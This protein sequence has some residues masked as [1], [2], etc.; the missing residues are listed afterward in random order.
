MTYF[1]RKNFLF[2][3]VLC[4]L[5]AIT[6][7][8]QPIADFTADKS[9][10]CAPVLIKF[11]NTSTQGPI[12]YSWDFGNG[13]TSTEQD[14]SILFSLPGLYTV[15]LTSTNVLG[16]TSKTI[17]IPV[18]A[19]P[20]AD[21]QANKTDLCGYSP[22]HFTDLSVPQ[23]TGII[24]WFWSFGDG[25]FSTQQN[26]VHNYSKEGKFNVYLQ[27]EDAN[28]CTNT[29][30][31]NNYIN[32]NQP[33]ADFAA[34]TFVCELPAAVQFTNKSTGSNLNYSWNFGDGSNS[35]LKSPKHT[36]AKFDT[37]QVSMIVNSTGST[38]SDTLKKTIRITDYKTNFNYTVSCNGQKDFTINFNNTGNPVG[39]INTW[40]FGDGDT[41][42]RV[43]PTHKFATK[44]TYN[45]RLI[46]RFNNTCI[47]T[48]T[49]VYTSPTA[50][51]TF[52]PLS[53]KAPFSVN[54]VNQS[55]GSNATS[56]WNF[57]N[58]QSSAQ[59]NPTQTYIVPPA[60]ATA[61]LTQSNV[62]GCAHSDTVKLNFP[63]PIAGFKV[64]TPFS[65]CAPLTVTLKDNSTTYGSPI[66]KWNWNFG[67]STSGVAN[68]STLKSPTHT[69]NNTGFYTVTLTVE[70][71]NGCTSSVTVNK[72]VKTGE[73]PSLVDFVTDA[74]TFCFHTTH[75]YTDK[76]KYSNPS[77]KP[78]YWC[79]SMYQNGSD[80][81]GVNGKL[82]ATCPDSGYYYA[83]ED[84][85]AIQNPQHKYEK[86]D[87]HQIT[88]VN[89]TLWADNAQAKTGTYYVNMIVGNNGCYAEV[90]KK[91]FIKSNMSMPNY[92]F[93]NGEVSLGAC[94]PPFS[95]GLFN[96]STNWDKFNYFNVVKRGTSDTII[97]LKANDTS[98]INITHSG[99]YDINISTTNTAQNC[100]DVLSRVI[101]VDSMIPKKIVQSTAC[102]NEPITLINLTKSTLGNIYD[103]DWDFGDNSSLG[104]PYAD[105]TSKA[106][107]D[108][109]SFIIHAYA[110]ARV[111]YNYLSA[112]I[113]S[114]Q[115][116]QN[117]QKDTIRIEGIKLNFGSAKNNYCKGDVIQFTDSSAS[118][119]AITSRWWKF[120]DGNTSTAVNPTHSYYT[121]GSY[122]VQLIMQNS[123]GCKDSISKQNYITITKPS[124][125]FTTNKTIGCIG[126]TIKFINQSSPSGSL[127][128]KWNFGGTDTSSATHP[129]FIFNKTGVFDI[130]LFV[131][132][133]FGCKDTNTQLKLTD[134]AALPVV[135]FSA[136]TMVANCSPFLV[137][138]YDS[139]KTNIQSWTWDF[140]EGA[141]SNE[142][143]AVN[144]YTHPGKFDVK[145][146]ATNA[147]GCSNSITKTKFITIKGP[148]GSY[149]LHPDSGC[150]PIK[151]LLDQDFTGTNFYVWNFGDGNIQS[152]NYAIKRD[153][154]YHDYTTKGLY[155][156]E[157][158][159]LDSNNCTA[160]LK[161]QKVYA[162]K[163]ISDFSMSD[164]IMC[165]LGN[166]QLSNLTSAQFPLTHNW[167]FGDNNSSVSANP[168]HAYLAQGNYT[169]TLSSKSSIG[170][171]D[172]ISKNV[173]VFKSPKIK[174]DTLTQL[175]CI[176]FKAE[177][178]AI[179]TDPTV[180]INKWFW[181]HN[182]VKQDSTFASYQITSTG[183]Q[184]FHLKIIYGET[185]CSIDSLIALNA[186]NPPKADFN[187]EP[188]N[189]SVNSTVFFT[190][191]SENTSGWKWT[192][193]DG[194][195]TDK[196]NT[197]K[198]YA[199]KGEYKITLYASNNGNC[200]DSISK[201]ISVSVSDFVKIVSG[202][203]PNGDGKNDFVKILNAGE[204][205]L[206]DLTIYNRWGELIFQT[207]DIEQ[208]WDGTY[209]GSL[210]NE[211]TFVYYINAINK[212]T[213]AEV[214][215]KGNITLIR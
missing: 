9:K 141:F 208:G 172:T 4:Q 145:L 48:V 113:T 201:T 133:Q 56:L 43:N 177:L 211:G 76:T 75:Q 120:G 195:T 179:N 69:Y 38:C 160:T 77:T 67:D 124:A 109:G 157:V 6:L 114:Y 169:I 71:A 194:S 130:N 83:I 19:S 139:S 168:L 51:F 92:I 93:P 128:Y 78:N 146:T 143:N 53:C 95:L 66:I 103:Y 209:K 196:P 10:G 40:D 180:Q 20:S 203:T 102:M 116:C 129:S 73:K 118:T 17:T 68:T 122:P 171:S 176:P 142:K 164:T 85:V 200:V 12:S 150:V 213:S 3:I 148:Y 61:I 156:P 13:S 173:Q 215:Q 187:L 7:C 186:Y 117:D 207:T 127:T 175:F 137:S 136:D 192:L 98:F 100:T 212:K 29:Y 149:V 111:P 214:F 155:N 57:S 191:N 63:I 31:L 35:T 182:S 105:T 123:Y 86:Y 144:N 41:A 8:A 18:Y 193:G 44:G 11:T 49:Q 140:G 90:K 178:K 189:P 115:E 153:S 50:K 159:L 25:L 65:G 32:I 185:Q 104:G 45:L 74:D 33:K 166:M 2:L 94:K 162:E 72:A 79:W 15:K 64:D 110:S 16:S 210:Q 108:T 206:I 82:P 26:P 55:T 58:G 163:V 152:F 62:W 181:E 131:S 170:C 197:A 190:D 204:M 23:S 91:V 121:S 165:S 21:F 37:V 28:E 183:T 87:K 101:T 132:N 34:D 22:I 1:K 42:M 107:A 125:A 30:V 80:L 202:F 167:N 46:S 5:F 96:G 135:N 54:F 106:Y 52:S 99:I 154:V 84:Y 147:N 97:K 14:P 88:N 174:I 59:L 138:F 36:Y 119:K 39:T 198:N 158:Q 134:I 81:L 24:K 205:K 199:K 47:D 60:V 161:G 184:D 188:E 27:I 89:D 151:V 126:D 70:N 112:N